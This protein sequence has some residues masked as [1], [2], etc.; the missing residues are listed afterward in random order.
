[1]DYERLMELANEHGLIT[2]HGGEPYWQSS[3]FVLVSGYVAYGERSPDDARDRA[4]AAL[5]A[6]LG[7]AATYGFTGADELCALFAKGDYSARAVE[8]A[9]ESMRDVPASE[10]ETRLAQ[11]GF[12]AG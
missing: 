5:D 6:L 11:A 3:L 12:G 10:L 1:M 8:L 2:M 4:R 7:A 9:R